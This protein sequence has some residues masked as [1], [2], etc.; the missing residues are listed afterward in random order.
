MRSIEAAGRRV[1]ID[2][3]EVVSMDG[4][5]M[6]IIDGDTRIAVLVPEGGKPMKSGARVRVPGT[7]DIDPHGNLRI[8][9]SGIETK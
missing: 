2:N 5:V 9:A 3:A 8:R 7:T 6:W 4:S 1:E